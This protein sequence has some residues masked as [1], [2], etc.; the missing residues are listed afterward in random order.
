MMLRRC[1]QLAPLI[2]EALPLQVAMLRRELLLSNCVKGSIFAS[3]LLVAMLGGCHR[4]GERILSRFNFRLAM[5]VVPAL[6]GIAAGIR[7]L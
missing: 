1:R 3:L 4:L 5:F 6:A 7:F 2:K